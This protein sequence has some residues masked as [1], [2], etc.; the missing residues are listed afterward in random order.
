M[1]PRVHRVSK[2]ALKQLPAVQCFR[3]PLRTGQQSLVFRIDDIGVEWNRCI[4]RLD[5]LWGEIGACSGSVAAACWWGGCSL[6]LPTHA[7]FYTRRHAKVQGW[8]LHWVSCACPQCELDPQGHRH[9]SVCCCCCVAVRA[10]VAT[11]N[12]WQLTALERYTLVDVFPI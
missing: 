6:P 12:C 7:V 11:G 3:A 5:C 2:T 8:S 1:I 10:H 9:C 4:T